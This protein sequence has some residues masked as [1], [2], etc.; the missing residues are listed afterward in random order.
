MRRTLA[1][2]GVLTV[3][4]VA[5]CGDE[6]AETSGSPTEYGSVSELVEATGAASAEYETAQ[7]T[8]TG[9]GDV[10]SGD[11]MSGQMRFGDD[12]TDLAMYADG[13]K[14]GIVL[15]D[16]VV[17][18]NSSQEMVP[19]KPW[20]RI[21]PE[22]EQKGVAAFLRL[23]A[24]QMIQSSDPTRTLGDYEKAARIV[25]A[26]PES[27][28]GTETVR[29]D[30][31]VDLKTLADVVEDGTDKLLIQTSVDMGVETVKYSMWVDGR[32]LPMKVETESMSPQGEP[33]NSTLT[34]DGWGDPVEIETPPDAKTADVSEVRMPGMP[35]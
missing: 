5:A 33:V 19:G 27:V 15:L 1:V 11:G 20:V 10:L 31:E 23:M 7:L 25:A 9:S 3:V 22:Q 28:D 26:E 6:S 30:V 35:N 4:S 24:R 17:Y 21:D 2:V 14:G 12:H 34:Y 13:A 16:E 32:D 8:L 18:L 29:H